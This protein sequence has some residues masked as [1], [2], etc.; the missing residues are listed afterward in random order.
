MLRVQNASHK[1]S[2]HMSDVAL[3]VCYTYTNLYIKTKNSC[4]TRNCFFFFVRT[5]NTYQTLAFL[6]RDASQKYQCKKIPVD[7]YLVK[8]NNETQEQWLKYVSNKERLPGRCGVDFIN[9]EQISHIALVFPLLTLNKLKLTG[10]QNVVQ[11][12]R[13]ILRN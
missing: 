1:N 3:L 2:K 7:I 4:V 12:G 9:F 13:R 11:Q 8:V 10:L 6:T 5:E